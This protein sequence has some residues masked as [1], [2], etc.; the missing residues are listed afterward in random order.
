MKNVL[1]KIIE[2]VHMLGCLL[3]CTNAGKSP[4]RPCTDLIQKFMSS[5]SAVA[6]ALDHRVSVSDPEVEK[7][8]V[9]CAPDL[10]L[11]SLYTGLFKS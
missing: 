7:L 5:F 1:T 4:R 2:Y 10:Q 11:D 3:D 8:R 9:T 6:T